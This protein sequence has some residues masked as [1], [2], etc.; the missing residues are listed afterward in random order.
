MAPS[1]S[2][3]FGFF[4]PPVTVIGRSSW[5]STRDGSMRPAKART[6]RCWSE[7][8]LMPLHVELPDRRDEHD[9]ALVDDQVA[10]LL[11]RAPVLQADDVA[12][13]DRPAVR[14]ARHGR[15]VGA[16]RHAGGAGDDGGKRDKRP[17]TNRRAGSWARRPPRGVAGPSAKWSCHLT[18]GVELRKKGRGAGGREKRA[19]ARR[20]CSGRLGRYG[21]TATRSRHTVQPAMYRCSRSTIVSKS[22]MS[23]RPLTCHGPVM[24]GA[25]S[26][27]T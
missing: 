11:G 21:A 24:P 19:R 4:T 15:D 25:T 26:N 5:T 18:W 10:R 3:T 2:C 17:Q 14:A 23:F 13:L 7:S 16:M 27:R 1:T 22:V 12:R 20:A 9:P 8:A 6:I